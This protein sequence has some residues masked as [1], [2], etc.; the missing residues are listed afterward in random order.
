MTSTTFVSAMHMSTRRPE[1]ADEPRQ[2]SPAQRHQELLQRFYDAFARRDATEMGACYHDDARFADPA[3]PDLDAAG[4]RAM[5][6]M[7]TARAPDLVVR[8][9]DF[10]VDGER[11]RCRWV[12][13]YTFSKRSVENHVEARFC[14]RDGLIVRHEDDFDFWRWSRQALGPVGLALGWSTVLKKT[15]QATAAKGLHRWRAEHEGRR[16]GSDVS[17]G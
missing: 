1:G 15:V 17:P 5:W 8:A 16:P 11:G 9:T 4:A 3:F 10:E 12:A 2:Q 7:L 14:F 6:S 13:S